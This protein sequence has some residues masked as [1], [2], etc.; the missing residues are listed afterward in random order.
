M[1]NF[2]SRPNYK[3]D[4]DFDFFN[5]RKNLKNKINCCTHWAVE[6][7]DFVGTQL[8]K[9]MTGS[10]FKP[11]TSFP[12]ISNLAHF[13]TTNCSS[14]GIELKRCFEGRKVSKVGE[15]RQK[16]RRF[17]HLSHIQSE[18]RDT[19]HESSTF[20]K[21]ASIHHTLQG[22]NWTLLLLLVVLWVLL[23]HEMSEKA[24]RF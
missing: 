21:Q 22:H 14:S 5:W 2:N 8:K 15:R 3:S 16:I 11:D 24:L 12:P 17:S 18:L 13:C 19:E 20:S 9:R 23:L 7:W 6:G 4:F 1:Q 10:S